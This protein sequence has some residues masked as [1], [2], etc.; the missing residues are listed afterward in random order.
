M[1]NDHPSPEFHSNARAAIDDLGS[2]LLPKIQEF[3][4]KKST[5][6]FPS[7]LHVSAHI[8][9]TDILGESAAWQVNLFGDKLGVAFTKGDLTYE[10][11]EE[12]YSLFKRISDLFLKNRWIANSVGDEFLEQAI[13]D[14]FRENIGQDNPASLCDFVAAKC[15][16]AV[17]SFTIWVPV[18]ACTRF[19]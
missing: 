10:L 17:D 16:K 8:T 12:T 2:Q 4:K 18:V 19:G 13:L 6:N 5:T 15:Q 9:D 3:R 1:S 11:N 7:Q 14:W